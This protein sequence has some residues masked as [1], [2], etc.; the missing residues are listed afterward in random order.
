MSPHT[1]QYSVSRNILL[2]NCRSTG[3]D[4]Q[5]KWNDVKPNTTTLN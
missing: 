5:Y 2:A 1:T 4:L 3:L